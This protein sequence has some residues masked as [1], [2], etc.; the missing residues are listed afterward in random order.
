MLPQP[1]LFKDMNT[2]FSVLFQICRGLY[3]HNLHAVQEIWVSVDVVLVTLT[4]Y[5]EVFSARVLFKFQ[6]ASN[7]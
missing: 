3:L 2:F 6:S 7:L 1:T 4:S 5:C